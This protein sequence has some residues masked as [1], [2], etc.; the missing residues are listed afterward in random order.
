MTPRFLARTGN[1]GGSAALSEGG[2]IARAGLMVED[3]LSF[4]ICWV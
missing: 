4:R 2:N 3:D 1:G